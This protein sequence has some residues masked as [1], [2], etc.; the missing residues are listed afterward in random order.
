MMEKTVDYNDISIVKP[1][2]SGCNSTCYLT[3]D[4]HVFKRFN[5]P[6][7]FENNLKSICGLHIP[8]YVFPQSVVTLESTI[9]GYIMEYVEG[10]KV[11]FLNKQIS[12]EEYLNALRIAEQDTLVLSNLRI[13]SFDLKSENVLYTPA[14]KM[15]VIDTDFY[16]KPKKRKGI[17]Q[18]NIGDLTFGTIEPLFDMYAAR[19]KSG[20]LENKR[21]DLIDGKITLSR[22][23]ELLLKYMNISSTKNITVE[24]M[25]NEIKLLY[26]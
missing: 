19:F 17:Y 10:V 14:G 20:H 24:E 18:D 6:K 25:S 1:L 15:K 9:I 21:G 2:G 23:L 8:T 22:Y 26:K 5:N 4:N 12:L 7:V 11:Q 13:H 3:T 16:Y